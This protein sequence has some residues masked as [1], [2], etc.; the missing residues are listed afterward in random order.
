MMAQIA[1]IGMTTERMPTERP[2]MMTVAG[3]VSPE[4]AISRTG[5]LE[6]KYSVTSPM[7]MP[8]IAP[9]TTAHQTLALTPTRLVMT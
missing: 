2:V 3:P 5:W 7:M 6:V 1:R 8:P 4:S 9:A